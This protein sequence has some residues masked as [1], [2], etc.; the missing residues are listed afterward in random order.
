MQSQNGQ[1]S[2]C[3][4]RCRCVAQ[5]GQVRALLDVED[6]Q[7]AGQCNG[8]GL[9]AGARPLDAGVV[10]DPEQAERLVGDAVGVS[11]T[12]EQRFRAPGEQVRAG[13]CPTDPDPPVASLH[14]LAVAAEAGRPLPVR[15]PCGHKAR[16]VDRWQVAGHLRIVPERSDS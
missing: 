13:A 11:S 16:R 2:G 6:R 7:L 15:Q 8:A 1:A 14:D 5:L 12:G 9:K 3:G 4:G 10:S